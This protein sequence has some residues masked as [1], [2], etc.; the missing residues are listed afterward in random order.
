[1]VI[2]T[3]YT[4]FISEFICSGHSVCGLTLIWKPS[5]FAC[6][7][8]DGLP[9]LHVDFN[10]TASWLWSNRRIHVFTAFSHMIFSCCRS[11][12]W[13][14]G[15]SAFKFAELEFYTSWFHWALRRGCWMTW[16]KE[17]LVADVQPDLSFCSGCQC[18]QIFAVSLVFLCILIFYCT[19]C[20]YVCMA[21]CR[22]PKGFL[23][24]SR[25]Q[26]ITVRCKVVRI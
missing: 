7:V 4:C 17:R 21:A 14:R 15:K 13:G 20:L 5:H 24:W 8:L 22:T 11:Q 25:M 3:F 16:R 2:Y 26:R 12:K 10:T 6:C 19:L 1:M 18:C 9:S 23:C